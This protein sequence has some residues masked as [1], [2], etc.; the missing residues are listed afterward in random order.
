VGPGQGTG[1]G[2]GSL[3]QGYLRE[4]RRLLERQKEYPRMAQ[5]LNMQGVAVLRFTIGADGGIRGAGLARSS[6]HGVLDA[7]AQETV[8]KVGRFPPL[9]AAL[10]REKLTIEIPLAFRLTN[11]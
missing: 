2:T 5:R 9:P 7:A 11:N 8:S 3:L 6:G 10:G 4:V 1:T